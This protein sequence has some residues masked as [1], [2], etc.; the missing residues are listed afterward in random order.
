[1]TGLVTIGESLGLIRANAIGSLVHE[2]ALT[3]GIGGAEGNVAIGVARLGSEATWVGRL[4]DDSVGRRIER[5]YRAEGVRVIAAHDA[6]ST[7]LM[8]KE[9]PTV[10]RTVVRYYRTSS[11]GSRIAPADLDGVDIEGADI[12][13]VTGIT[14]AL[15]ATARATVHS[16]VDRAR[17]SGVTVSFD[18]NHRS[19]LWEST[20]AAALEYREL[21]AKADIVFAGDDEASILVEG[22]SPHELA[23]ALSRL[24][25]GEVVIKLGAQGCLARANG[26]ELRRDAV[27]VTVV[28]TVGAGDAFVAGYLAERMRGLPLADRLETAVRAGALACTSAGDWEGLPTRAE[29]G[30]SPSTDP[31]NR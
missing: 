17:R 25:P 5:E 18:V 3:L 21:A 23:E 15:S 30:A 16:A 11:A 12:L 4:G 7:A 20:A 14:L 31:V 27:P 9:R 19:R 6:A 8:L 2:S 29:L 26:V 13:H 22:E 24:G 28:D 1:M 10:D